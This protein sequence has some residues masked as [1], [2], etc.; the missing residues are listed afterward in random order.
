V[1]LNDVDAS[2]PVNAVADDEG[3]QTAGAIETVADGRLL[4]AEA[5]EVSRVEVDGR[6]MRLDR[7]PTDLQAAVDVDNVV[8]D[9]EEPLIRQSSPIVDGRGCRM[10]ARHVSA[11][12]ASWYGS[13]L[14]AF[15]R[16]RL[17]KRGWM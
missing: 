15:I 1:P 11:M 16:F 8:T 9:L 14:W 2:I 12:A 4:R 17:L 3:R 10:I 7:R 6:E 5:Q 13:G